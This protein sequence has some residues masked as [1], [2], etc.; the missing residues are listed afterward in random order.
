MVDINTFRKIALSFPETTEQ[1]HFEKPSFRVAKKIFATLDIKNKIACIKLSSVDQ[2]VFSAFD[3]KIIYPVPNKWGQQGWT[4]IN[5]PNVRK[6]MFTD[7]LTTAYLQVAPKK[8]A[9]LMKQ[10]SKK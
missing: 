9:L 10:D 4:F 3:K 6:D 5:L 8:M 1:P 2:D 7:A